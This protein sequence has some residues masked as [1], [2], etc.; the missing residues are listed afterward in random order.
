MRK[1]ATIQKIVELNPIP[2]ADAIECAK[3]WCNY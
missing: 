3:I 2:K 1:L